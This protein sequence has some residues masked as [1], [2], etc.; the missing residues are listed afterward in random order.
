MIVDT[1][2]EIMG[3]G[4]TLK[5]YLNKGYDIKVN[6][7]TIVKIS[8]LIETSTIKINCRCELC[9]RHNQIKYYNYIGNI[10]R[11]NI[12]RCNEC[13]KSIRKEKIKNIFQDSAKSEEIT[14]KRRITSKNNYGT[15]SPMQSQ[16]V[17]DK[18]R[19]TNIEKYGQDNVMKNSEIK[20]KLKNSILEKYGVSHY[21]KTDDF[22]I[23]YKA[24]C[25]KNFGVENSFQSEEI[26]DKIRNTNLERYGVDNPTKNLEIFEKAQKHSYKIFRYNNTDFTY[27]GTYELD[28]LNFCFTNNIK[29]SKGPC[30]NYSL[31]GKNR[32]YFSDFFIEELNLICE[33]K[34]S[35]TYFKDLEE[36]L[37]KRQF[38]ENFGYKLLFIIDKNYE[39]FKEYLNM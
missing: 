22:K 21:S 34:S 6:Q 32:K 33:I 37:A 5:H 20:E 28:F 38:S 23:K 35:W 12:Y 10:K 18:I 4:K 27:Q 15:D 11:N 13:S 24:K 30:V 31:N 36:N 39:E 19:K 14:K 1:E 26:K 25:L 16:I 17:K 2:V 9:N 29:I 8:D 3:N 7:K